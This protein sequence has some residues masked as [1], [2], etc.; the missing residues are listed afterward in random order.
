MAQAPRRGRLPDRPFLAAALAFALVLAIGVLVRETVAPQDGLFSSPI[1]VISLASG[2]AVGM[3]L[4]ALLR[5]YYGR[6][7]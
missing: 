4:G 2:L 1:G 6:A 7:R 3:L 5:R